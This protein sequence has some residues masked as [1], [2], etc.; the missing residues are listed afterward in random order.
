M[1][2]P[3]VPA[4]LKAALELTRTEHEEVDVQDVPSSGNKGNIPYPPLEFP[5]VPSSCMREIPLEWVSRGISPK[6]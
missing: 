6:E 4:A 5:P 1:C 3:S 2:V